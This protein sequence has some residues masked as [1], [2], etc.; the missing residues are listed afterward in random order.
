M[1]LLVQ[2]QTNPWCNSINISQTNRTT[3]FKTMK[4]KDES[5]AGSEKFQ[6]VSR[7]REERTY[8]FLFETKNGKFSA[9]TDENSPKIHLQIEKECGVTTCVS[10]EVKLKQGKGRKGWG[11]V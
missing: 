11:E 4:V 10:F 3:C 6:S 8:A 1:H 5:E 7:H 2:Y 9:E